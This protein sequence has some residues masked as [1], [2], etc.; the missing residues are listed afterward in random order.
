M[1]TGGGR[2]ESPSADNSP[3]IGGRGEAACDEGLSRDPTDGLFE[4]QLRQTEL[5]RERR[6]FEPGQ[7]ARDLDRSYVKEE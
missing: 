3:S 1:T 7:G 2:Q 6:V 4:A 5:A